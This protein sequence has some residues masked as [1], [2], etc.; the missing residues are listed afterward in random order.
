M[1]HGRGARGQQ[2]ALYLAESEFILTP[3]MLPG[4]WETLRE[5][6]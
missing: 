1:E 2:G 4:L 5:P 6:S 3:E